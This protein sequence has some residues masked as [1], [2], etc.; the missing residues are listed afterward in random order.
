L[1]KEQRLV[2]FGGAALTAD[3]GNGETR[4]STKQRDENRQRRRVREAA[5][6]KLQQAEQ[7]HG[8]ALAKAERAQA[9]LNRAAAELEEARE[10]ERALSS[11]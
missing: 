3:D 1:D 2:G 8:R 5:K 10:R 4:A 11:S 9:E 6:R 7:A